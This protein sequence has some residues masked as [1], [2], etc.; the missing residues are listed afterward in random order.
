MFLKR[1]MCEI[2]PWRDGETF[3]SDGKKKFIFG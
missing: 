1:R 2:T 3:T